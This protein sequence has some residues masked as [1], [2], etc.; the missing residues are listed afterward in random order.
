MKIGVCTPVMV[1]LEMA[2]PSM[3]PPSTISSERPEIV[4]FQVRWRCT[5]AGRMEQ[6]WIVMSRNPPVEAV[7]NLIALQ[8]LA[9]T[10]L[11]TVT[12]WHGSV[13]W[14]LRQIPSSSES[15][16]QSETFT[17]DESMSSPSLLRFAWL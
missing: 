5:L 15:I 6:F 8:L 3:T 13:S 16:T 2:I 7:P 10:Q 17:S 4:S 14:L 1:M 12:F 11:L 9:T